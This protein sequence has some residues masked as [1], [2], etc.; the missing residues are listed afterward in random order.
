MSTQITKKPTVILASKRFEQVVALHILKNNLKKIEVLGE[1][2]K[3]CIRPFRLHR[4][5]NEQYVW[6]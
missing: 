3:D 6:K 2:I 4:A 1:R 5:V